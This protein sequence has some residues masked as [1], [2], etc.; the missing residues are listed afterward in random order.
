MEEDSSDSVPE[1]PSPTN[2]RGIKKKKVIMGY[3]S[4]LHN[5]CWGLFQS[6]EEPSEHEIVYKD[7]TYMVG[8]FVYIEPR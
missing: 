6:Q 3:S 1:I 7:Q 8:D 5:A 4:S 2:V